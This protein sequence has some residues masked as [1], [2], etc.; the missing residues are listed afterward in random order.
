MAEELPG[1]KRALD[2]SDEMPLAEG[3]ESDEEFLLA[4]DLTKSLIKAIKTFRFYPPD[5]PIVKGFQ[6][7][8]P[9]KFQ[10][11]LNKYYS[12]VLQVGEYTLSYK[13]KILYENRDVKASLAFL[14]YKDGIRELRFLRGLEEWEAK[15]F[16]D[17]IIRCDNINQLEDDFVTLLWEK[18]FSHISYLA[19]DEFLEDM[20]I[21][22]PENVEQFRK[23]LVFKPISHEVEIDFLEEDMEE[24]VDLD[25]TLSK[26][27]EELHSFVSN[28]SVYSLT[29]EE[30]ERLRKEVESEIEPTFVLNIVD[31]LF[32]ILVWEKE[33][34][35][36]GRAV[37]FLEK[38]LDAM[39]T[40]REFQK[41]IDLLKR[42]Y[43]FQRTY[44]L[45]DWQIESLRKFITEA[46]SE[47]RIDRI[48]KL[49]D[50]EEEVRSED[51][52]NYLVLLQRNAIKPLVRV[53]GERTKSKTRRVICD[54]L[55]EI[56]KH[57][58]ELFIPYMDDPRWYLV[59]NITYIL[60]RIGAEES[61]SYIQK[62]F[63]HEDSRVKREA[64]LALGVIGSTKAV[65]MLV[66]ALTDGDARIRAMAAI[67]L[68]KIGKKAALGPLLEV[69]QAKDFPRKEPAEMKAFFDAIGMVGGSQESILALQQLLERKSWF[70]RG[71]TD[72]IRIGAAQALAMVG[73][74]EAMAILESGKDSKD[75]SMRNACTQALRSKSAKEGTA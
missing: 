27:I 21:F 43:I 33:P 67:N 29:P 64:I 46:G 15:G 30:M 66:K 53:L 70:S 57:S 14:F 38:I 49:L 16:I 35:P 75:E 10:F 68:G 65:G 39:L 17:I 72:E 56:G 52:Q 6:E 45:K 59:R 8:L 31:I 9:K 22:I 20:P 54:A 61:L 1:E 13:G 34:E 47:Q 44:E 58:Y 32:E 48:G 24:G 50:E 11:F 4:H 28:R 26:L 55:S 12:L 25:E 74:P 63:N 7:L 62:A 41:A 36:Y 71:K 18:D 2:L 69:V 51:V 5:N 3:V 40:L 73:T 42:V 19:T 37:N 23:D 60:G